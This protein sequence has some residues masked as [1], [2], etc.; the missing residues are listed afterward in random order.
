M[1]ETP[2]MRPDEELLRRTVREFLVALS[3]ARGLYVR[4]DEFSNDAAR[5]VLERMRP[6]LEAIAARI[7]RIAADPAA[8]RD[9]HY[10]RR[11]IQ[12]R[13]DRAAGHRGGDRGHGRHRAVRFPRRGGA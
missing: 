10:L 9:P 1:Y 11:E 6:T 8:R 5:T 4:I 12:G 2:D 3:I 13:A 7:E